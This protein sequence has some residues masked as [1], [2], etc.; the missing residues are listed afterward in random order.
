MLDPL[1]RRRFDL[2]DRRVVVLGAG[3]A[4]RMAAWAF[5]SRGAH[6]EIAARRDERAS[7]V[8]VEIG[9]A[10]SAWPPATGWDLLVNTTPVG[11][12][13]RVDESPLDRAAIQGRMVYDLIYNPAETTLL[14]R[15]REAGAATIGG[16]EMLVGQACLQF[17]WWTGRRA[18]PAVMMTA[19]R[20]F[21]ADVT[22][23]S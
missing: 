18:D 14:R 11:T 7:A 22:R 16:L 6:V 12:W 3:G 4:G 19:A 21:V 23:Q 5:A 10:A 13:P 2:R 9:V 15:A 8:A 20:A 17:E 1:D